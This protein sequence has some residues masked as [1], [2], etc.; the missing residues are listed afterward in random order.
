MDRYTLLRVTPRGIVLWRYHAQRLG[1]HKNDLSSRA[2]LRWY[3]GVT[4]GIWSITI[5]ASGEL[6][7][8]ARPSSRLHEGIPVRVR[9]SPWLTEALERT[10]EPG[11]LRERMELE[12]VGSQSHGSELATHMTELAPH[13]LGG[14]PKTA[15]P[16]RYDTVR[17]PGVA[18]LLSSADG[19]ELFEACSA[20][21][22]AWEDGQ[23]LCVP[24]RCPRVDSTSERALR[25]QLS[26]R[27]ASISSRAHSLLLVNAVKGTCALAAP[28]SDG[29]PLS[30]RSVVDT[31]LQELT[32]HPG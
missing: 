6:R 29:F 18:T 17:A 7:A 10:E 32:V 14:F 24:R 26:V 21:V 8:K 5:T 12:P 3:E 22:I 27:E 16:D 28:W 13:A 2:L 20:A 11:A 23:I 30:A 1:L 15:P 4:P 31:L 25:E 19:S 9:R